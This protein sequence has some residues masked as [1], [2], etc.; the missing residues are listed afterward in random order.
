MILIK[1]VSLEALEPNVEQERISIDE[2]KKW[3]KPLKSKKDEQNAWQ[4]TIWGRKKDDKS[5]IKCWVIIFL[6]FSGSFGH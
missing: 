3:K 5:K 2:F 1:N 6:C 4:R